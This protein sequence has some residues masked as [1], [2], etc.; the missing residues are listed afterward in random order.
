MQRKLERL[1]VIAFLFVGGCKGPSADQAAGAEQTAGVER[2]SLNAGELSPNQTAKLLGVPRFELDKILPQKEHLNYGAL[3]Q[4]QRQ[5]GRL[6]NGLPTF[7]ISPGRYFILMHLTELEKQP[8][9]EAATAGEARA[10]PVTVKTTPTTTS[11]DKVDHTP[12][13]T[14]VKN[15]RERGTCTAFAACADLEAVLLARNTRSDLSENLAYYWFM[16]EEGST[17]CQDTGIA[18]FK[19]AEYLQKHAVTLSKFWTY[20]PDLSDCPK[21]DVPPQVI[22]GQDGWS[23]K[24]YTLLPAGT[25]VE[26][27]GSIDI[28][29]TKTLESL[30]SQGRNIVFGCHVAWRTEDLGGLIDVITGPA[31]QPIFGSGGHAML[32]VG[33]DKSGQVHKQPHFIV[34]NSWGKELGHNGYLH[35][36]YDYIRVYAKYGYV[37]TDIQ[38]MPVKLP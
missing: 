4:F 27:N 1:V 17:P 33:F 3:D 8:K 6:R 25:E 37:T 26:P 10:Q 16:R 35:M 29:D 21:V 14:D 32:I 7:Q 22:N 18:T 23:I 28:K 11:P 36:T 34:K 19:A 20:V 31:G 13:Q 12:Q 9:K 24:T 30:L 38:N 5:F 15:Q 2:V